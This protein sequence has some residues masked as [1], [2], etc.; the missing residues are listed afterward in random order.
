MMEM[1]KKL[2]KVCGQAGPAGSDRFSGQTEKTGR[3]GMV[4][5]AKYLTAI[6]LSALMGVLLA[7]CSAPQEAADSGKAGTS[8]DQADTSQPKADAS[9]KKG[10]KDW[11]T[12]TITLLCP[13][14]AGSGTDLGARYLSPL[15]SKELGVN[16]VVE[17]VTGSGGW[18]AWNQ[19]IHNTPKDGYTVGIINHN[20]VTGAYDDATPRQDTLDDIT[21][22]SN[23][24]IDYNVMAIRPNETRFT[25]MDSFIDYA[26][27]NSILISAQTTGITDG[28]A[29][30]AQWFNKTYGTKI[31]IVPVDGA[32]D[33]RSMFLAGDTD[34]YFASV[35]DVYTAHNNSEL[36][37]ICVFAPERSEF[38]PDVPTLKEANGG[39]FIGFACRGYFYPKGVDTAIVDKMTEA[40]LKVSQDEEYQKNMKTMGLTPNTVSG[41]EYRDLL[42]SQLD[43]RKEIWGIQ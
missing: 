4:K 30:A 21:L 27:E 37:T 41:T 42:E 7:G 31:E 10:D 36:K 5:P 32:S 43:T 17:N 35:G 16:V 26:K 33:G 13:F 38:L 1:M 40:I 6:G 20:F 14:S 34:I 3:T 28:D 15:L 12:E 19:I 24:V 23:Q 9:G 8:Q 39:D 11:P 29:S 18:I 22:L 25:D 2:I